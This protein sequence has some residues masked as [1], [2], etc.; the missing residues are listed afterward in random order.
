[1]VTGGVHTSL[2]AIKAVMC[3][4]QAVQMVSALLRHGP[5][6]LREVREGIA[7]WLEEHEYDSL[8]QMQ[9]SMSLV[10]CPDPKAYERAN[11]IETLQ[12]W[13]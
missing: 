2:D 12:S 10:R 4:A 8:T 9:G 1:A 3:G 6:R 7:R 11:Y 13:R 5:N